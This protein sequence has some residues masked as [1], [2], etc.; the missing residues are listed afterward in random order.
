MKRKVLV[1]FLFIILCVCGCGKEEKEIKRVETKNGKVD[2][3]V[4]KQTDEQTNYVKI[5]MMNN[6]IIIV[7]LYP[8]VAPIT[9]EN[10]KKLVNEK[11]YDGLIFHRVIDGFMIQGGDPQGTGMGGSKDTIKGEFESNGVKNKLSHKRGVISMA[12]SQLKDSASSQFF[13]VQADS[14]FLDG[15]YA[16]FGKTIAGLDV[17]DKIAKVARDDNDKPLQ[18]QKMMSIRFVEIEE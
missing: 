18:E 6:D 14:E 7:E 3:I 5:E 16:A 13:I 8:D 11:F 12:R 2:G 17:V 1:L 10:F 15:E 4:F 9:V